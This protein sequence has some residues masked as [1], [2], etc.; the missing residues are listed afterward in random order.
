MNRTKLKNYAPQARRDFI[1]AMTDRAAY[2]GLTL[3]QVEPIVERGDVAIIAGREFPRAVTKKRKA[4]E[5]RIQRQ[6]FE[7]T[8]EAMAYTW[9][10]RLVAIRFMELHGYLDHGYRVLS[11]RPSTET[12]EPRK[13]TELHGSKI[14]EKS[15]YRVASVSFS[16]PEILQYAEHVEWLGLKKE[17]IIDL[18][19]AGNKEGELYRLLL[20]AQCNALHA[21]M[22]FLF[23]KIDDETELLLPDNLLHSDSLIRKLVNEI[24]EADWQEVEIIGWLYQF[25]I[26]EKKDQVIGKVVAS[27]DIPAATQLFTPNWI[28]KYLVQNTLGRQWLEHYPDSPLKAQMAYYIEPAEQTP[29]VQAQLDALIAARVVEDVPMNPSGQTKG[30]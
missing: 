27:A 16:S 4:L 19:L 1:Q 30:D 6:G 17:T 14:E 2:Y 13:D 20:T 15:S 10:N 3:N 22:P 11:S 9:F 24:D 12:L 28:V 5:D 26:S 23:E 7:A 8:M 25:Y 21:A 29:E 18:K